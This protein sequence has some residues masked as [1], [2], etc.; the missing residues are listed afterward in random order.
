MFVFCFF[1]RYGFSLFCR[2]ALNPGLHRPSAQS[3]SMWEF[4]PSSKF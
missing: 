2:P 3:P 4:M 1:L